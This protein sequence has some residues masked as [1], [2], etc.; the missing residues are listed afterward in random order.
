MKDEDYLSVTTTFTSFLHQQANNRFFHH[1]HNNCKTLATREP[2]EQTYDM[3]Y[4]HLSFS[5]APPK[6][7][8]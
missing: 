7:Y 8:V 2:V 1:D 3:T 4:V 5:N 6:F